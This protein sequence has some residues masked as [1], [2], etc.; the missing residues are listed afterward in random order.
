MRPLV[1]IIMY[2][3]L[4][5]L[6]ANAQRMTKAERKAAKYFNKA[7]ALKAAKKYGEACASMERSIAKYPTNAD[8]YSMLGE[9]Y[10]SGHDFEKAAETFTK[11]SAKCNNGRTRFAKALTRSLI[12]AGRGDEALGLI[13]SHATIRD[14]SE[15]NKLRVQAEFV[16]A[17]MMRSWGVWPVN[18][19]IRV[20]SRYPELFPSMAVDTQSLFFTRRVN[21]MDEELF[22]APADSCGGWFAARN[23]GDPPNSPNQESA[24]F[25]SAD[26]HYLFF[27]RCENMS[28][29][30]SA[31]GGCDL[32]MAY[33]VRLDGPWTIAQPFGQT[34]NNPTYEGMPTLSPDNRELYFVSDRKGGFG[35]Y[36]IWVSRFENGLWQLPENAGPAINTAGNETTPFIAA[37]NK[38]LFFASDHRPGLGGTDIFMSRRK[39][40]NTWTPAENLGYPINSAHDDKSEFVSLDGKTLY[41]ASDRNGPAGNYDIYQVPLPGIIAPLPVSYLQGY[42]FDSISGER[43]NSAVMLICNAATGDTLYE[44]RSNRGDASYVITLQADK[45]YAVHTARL[46]Y[47]EVSDTVALTKEYAAKPLTH[48]VAMLPFGYN[49]IK[50]IND[51]LI[52]DVHFEVNVAELSAADKAT[53]QAIISPWLEEKGIVIYVNAYTDNTGTPMINE[54]LSAKRSQIVAQEIVSMGIDESMVEAKGWGEANPIASNDTEEGRTKNRR[55][56]IIVKR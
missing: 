7:L 5:P 12:Y 45:K 46:G 2:L 23:A 42:V 25:V 4:A 36:D 48:N 50:P 35:G 6:E 44:L 51:S 47:Q 55:V 22:Y 30:G 16:K 13:A 40:N 27:T 34:I 53:L 24:Q 18:L 54:T 28:E 29:N 43:L 39:A 11:A 38:T 19:G 49:P 32:F 33:R 1:Y 3:I 56:E 14:S 17:A 52:G 8:A 37:D 10:F 9:W 26:G 41:F 21:N 31:E 15:W 20:N